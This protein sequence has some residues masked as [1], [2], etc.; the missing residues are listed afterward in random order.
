ALSSAAS[1]VYKRLGTMLITNLRENDGR[2]VPD[3]GA[4]V[5][6]LQSPFRFVKVSEDGGY[7]NDALYIVTFLPDKTTET[8]VL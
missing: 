3:A 5:Q 2:F 7:A 8:T 1:V 6:G 4:L